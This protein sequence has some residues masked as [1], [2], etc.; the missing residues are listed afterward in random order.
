MLTVSHPQPWV[1]I[2]EGSTWVPAPNKL[3][4]LITCSQGP[5]R[6][7]SLCLQRPGVSWFWAR[8]RAVEITRIGR[9]LGPDHSAAKAGPGAQVPHLTPLPSLAPQHGTW[10]CQE[11]WGGQQ[12]RTPARL[13]SASQPLTAKEGVQAPGPEPGW[14]LPPLNVTST[15]VSTSTHPDLGSRV[16]SVSEVSLDTAMPENRSTAASVLCGQS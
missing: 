13:C 16:R 8:T 1:Q 15:H 5:S 7:S 3:V 11:W 2:P 12:V 6:A 9:A 10:P 4:G 14:E